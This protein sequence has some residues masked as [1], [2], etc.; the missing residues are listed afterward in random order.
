MAV[1]P[2]LLSYVLGIPTLVGDVESAADVLTDRARRGDGGYACLCNVHT[3]MLAQSDESVRDALLE[4][5]VVL[6]DGAPVA[7]LQRRHGWRAARRVAGADLMD[8][9]I[10]RGRW[11]R[12]RHFFFGSTEPVLSR[13][14]R[15]LDAR[16]PGVEISGTAAPAFGEAAEIAPPNDVGSAHVVWCGLGAPKQELWMRNWAEKLAPAVVVGVGAAFDFVAGTKPRAPEW[17][18]NHGLEWLHRLAGEPRR[19]AGRYLT[20][21]TRFVFEAAKDLASR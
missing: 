19:L 17:M 6:P 18:Q 1:P 20:T 9:V 3:L 12:L 21:N 7:W 8:A 4:A 11:L 13:L 15:E 16:H 10:E 2:H 5:A 14:V